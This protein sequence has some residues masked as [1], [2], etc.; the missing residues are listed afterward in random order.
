MITTAHALNIFSQV[1]PVKVSQVLTGFR[2]EPPSINR[3]ISK[4]LAPE[5]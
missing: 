5:E 3:T 4:I 2:M 1:K